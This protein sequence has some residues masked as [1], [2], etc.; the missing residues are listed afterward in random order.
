MNLAATTTVSTAD[1]GRLRPTCSRRGARASCTVIGTFTMRCRVTVAFDALP[2]GPSTAVRIGRLRTAAV[3]CVVA[4]LHFCIWCEVHSETLLTAAPTSAPRHLPYTRRPTGLAL[5]LATLAEG[6]VR[7]DSGLGDCC[8]V[9]GRP[10]RQLAECPTAAA[11]S[12]PSV[13]RLLPTGLVLPGSFLGVALRLMACCAVLLGLTS[14]LIPA[15]PVS[16]FIRLAA[17]AALGT[18]TVARRSR[19]TTGPSSSTA[20]PR[21]PAVTISVTSIIIVVTTLRTAAR[22][23]AV[24]RAERADVDPLRPCRPPLLPDDAIMLRRWAARIVRVTTAG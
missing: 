11:L 5:Y 12:T 9:F 19:P 1:C 23:A 17:H 22:T 20:Y 4:G 14:A 7:P 13:W 16:A 10:H 15:S 3:G 8:V 24:E 18:P 2:C 21:V 6:R